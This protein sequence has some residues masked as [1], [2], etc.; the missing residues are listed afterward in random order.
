LVKVVQRKVGITGT[1]VDGKFGPNTEAA[2]R[3]FQRNHDIVP[4]GIVGPK[5]W[6]KLDSIS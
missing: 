1:N 3:R 5:T 4:D 6:A 2:V